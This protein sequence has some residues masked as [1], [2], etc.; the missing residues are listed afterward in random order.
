MIFQTSLRFA[1]RDILL[2]PLRHRPSLLDTLAGDGAAVSP[3][4]PAGKL[5]F[6][7]QADLRISRYSD[8]VLQDLNTHGDHGD[9]QRLLSIVALGLGGLFFYSGLILSAMARTG[10]YDLF[11]LPDF[12]FGGNGSRLFHWVAKGSWRSESPVGKLFQKIFRTAVKL[13]LEGTPEDGRS[14]LERDIK[15][16]LTREAKFE[17]ASGLVE[18]RQPGGRE[19]AAT[20]PIAGENFKRGEAAGHWFDPIDA[21]TLSTQSRIADTPH[22][23]KLVDTFNQQNDPGKTGLASVPDAARHFNA[24]RNQILQTLDE[25]RQSPSGERSMESLFLSGLRALLRELASS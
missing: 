13:G 2:E 24:A 22:L 14:D 15:I 5:E 16:G 3:A 23:R 21:D 7:T 9:V 12:Y 8:K 6:Y 17:V 19:H 25:A 20:P 4:M 18:N 10:R 1:G 11:T